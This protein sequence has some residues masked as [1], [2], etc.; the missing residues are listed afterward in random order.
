MGLLG[1]TPLDFPILLLGQQLG[2]GGFVFLRTRL[3]RLGD[4]RK[5]ALLRRQLALDFFYRRFKSCDRRIVLCLLL[6]RGFFAAR[7]VVRQVADFFDRLERQALVFLLGFRSPGFDF[8]QFVFGRQTA[9]FLRAQTPF[10]FGPR[11]VRRLF[12]CPEFILQLLELRADRLRPDGHVLARFSFGIDSRLPFRLEPAAL[13]LVFARPP[14]RILPQLLDF[15]L[16]PFDVGLS[17]GQPFAGQSQRLFGPLLGRALGR[18]PRRYVGF[19]GISPACLFGR[20]SFG[21]FSKCLRFRRH[22]AHA[23]F[24]L[25]DFLFGRFPRMAAGLLHHPNRLFAGGFQLGFLQPEFFLKPAFRFFGF[26]H[27]PVRLFPGKARLFHPCGVFGLFLCAP[28]GFR[29]QRRFDPFAFTLQLL[30]AQGQ[31][32]RNGGPLRFGL[33]QP[34]LDL[35]P[36]LRLPVEFA[37]P[38]CLDRVAALRLVFELPANAFQFSAVLLALAGLFFGQSGQLDIQFP[39]LCLGL[40][41]GLGLGGNATPPFFLGFGA[42]SQVFFGFALEFGLSLFRV[43][44]ALDQLFP[45]PGQLGVQFAHRGLRGFPNLGLF[46]RRRLL[47]CKRSKV[48][49]LLLLGAPFRLFPNKT[50]FIRQLFQTGFKF[51]D[52]FFRLSP[53]LLGRQPAVPFGLFA[54][55]QFGFG[56]ISP[57]GFFGPALFVFFALGPARF[58]GLS[59]RLF[60]LPALVLDL[61]RALFRLEPPLPFGVARRLPLGFRLRAPLGFFLGAAFGFFARGL[62]GLKALLHFFFEQPPVLLRGLRAPLGVLPRAAI[63]LFPGPARLFLR[64]PQR[65]FQLPPAGL[66]QPRP[67]FGVVAETC[68]LFLAANARNQC[69][70]GRQSLFLH[71]NRF[72]FVALPRLHPQFVAHAVHGIGHFLFDG[73]CVVALEQVSRRLRRLRWQYRLADSDMRR[74]GFGFHF[75]VLVGA[76]VF[77]RFGL[78]IRL[79]GFKTQAAG[80]PRAAAVFFNRLSGGGFRPPVRRLR[81]RLPA[82]PGLR[83]HLKRLFPRVAEFPRLALFFPALLEFAHPALDARH[84]AAL[85]RGAFL[86][87]GLAGLAGRPHVGFDERLGIQSQIFAIHAN[88]SL[89]VGGRNQAPI[90]VALHRVDRQ[91]LEMG[92]AGRFGDRHA[93]PFPRLPQHGTH[94]GHPIAL[95][96]EIR[97][98]ACVLFRP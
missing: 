50:R 36:R 33:L 58:N 75:G 7:Q 32:R 98:P 40:A 2:P 18:L 88:E 59:Q 55:L 43:S 26:A 34:F 63:R 3:G 70:I 20:Q 42:L 54:R 92:C 56:R 72:E 83:L 37:F 38:L 35:G 21:R 73:R 79:V 82:R 14:F 57:F 41:S 67:L 71:R 48:V 1:R 80:C 60:D 12:P 61:P 25:P 89:R 90:V 91:N 28:F 9:G 22:A 19:A 93:H 81:L 97:I 85:L 45:K 39:A 13:Q 15:A 17:R 53:P 16:E 51:A 29:L 65:F 94:S 68:A 86:Q 62:L 49:C 78:R 30:V 10:Q 96:A 66:G 69:R 4:L 24:C 77:G 74:I 47:F 84:P 8:G 46:F 11:L 27:L 87:L 95:L 44:F 5:L 23:L 64:L 31:F 6:P 52:S 76:R